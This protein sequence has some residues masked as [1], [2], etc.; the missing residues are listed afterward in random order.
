MCLVPEM[1]ERDANS[2]HQ[3]APGWH[4]CSQT[5]QVDP[6]R[7]SLLSRRRTASRGTEDDSARAAQNRLLSSPPVPIRTDGISMFRRQ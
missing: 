3:L 6:D 7:R 4:P 1:T 5:F 2:R